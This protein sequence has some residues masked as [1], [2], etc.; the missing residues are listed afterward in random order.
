MK[1]FPQKFLNAEYFRKFR[2][3]KKKLNKKNE[4]FE[5]PK[6]LKISRNYQ[7]CNQDSCQESMIG[8]FGKLKIWKFSGKS[9]SCGWFLKITN[10]WK[11]FKK[12]RHF[13]NSGLGCPH[14]PT[15]SHFVDPL[16]VGLYDLSPTT[17]LVR[18]SIP[19]QSSQLFA[20]HFGRQMVP[21]G[22]PFVHCFST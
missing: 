1:N 21:S 16:N 6:V 11:F 10:F 12:I 22:F 13:Y 8:K 18:G 14:F 3:L 15:H 20:G 4:N 17:H 5:N 19:W 9:W 2:K 7:I